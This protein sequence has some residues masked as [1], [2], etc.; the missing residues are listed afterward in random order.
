MSMRAVS[1]L[2]LAASLMCAPA[3][4]AADGMFQGRVVD[5]PVNEAVR[6]GWIFVE[7]RNHML[8][9]VEVSHASVIF[10]EQ[11]PPSQRHSCR[12]ECLVV[13]QEVQVI[14]EQDRAGEWRAK[15]VVILKVTSNRI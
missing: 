14:A 2:L 15:R 6:A 10:G 3:V 1:A 9:R 11:V 8:R 12:A 13:G 5:P 7:G 4:R